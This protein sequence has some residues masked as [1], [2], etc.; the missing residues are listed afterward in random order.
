MLVLVLVL[1]PLVLLVLV[2]VLS[3]WLVLPFELLPASLCS[4]SCGYCRSCYFSIASI[5]VAIIVVVVPL[6]C[7][8][9]YH[10]VCQYPRFF[11]FVAS[12]YW[13]ALAVVQA[14]TVDCPRLVLSAISAPTCARV[15]L[16]D[17][18][19]INGHCLPRIRLRFLEFLIKAPYSLR[20]QPPYY[21]VKICVL[22]LRSRGHPRPV[23]P[24]FPGSAVTLETCKHAFL[25]STNATISC[26]FSLSCSTNATVSCKFSLSCSTNATVSCKIFLHT[27]D[28]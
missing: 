8:Y 19:S 16:H 24:L 17:G 6:V 7:C 20:Q 21:L 25:F 5:D 18:C 2:L 14:A 10:D 9:F 28:R 1:V 4:Y 15:F 27:S 13:T 26:K 23:S 22:S 3:P 11:W 12:I